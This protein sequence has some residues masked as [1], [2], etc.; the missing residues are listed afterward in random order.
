LKSDIL[1]CYSQLPEA[2]AFRL[3]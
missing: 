3:E 2:K 1:L